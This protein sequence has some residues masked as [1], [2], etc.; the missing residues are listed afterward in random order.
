MLNKRW[1]KKRLAA[2]EVAETT[3]KFNKGNVGNLKKE[4]DKTW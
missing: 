2:K 3:R 1:I 4:V